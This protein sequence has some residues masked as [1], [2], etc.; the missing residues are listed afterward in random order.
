MVVVGSM[1]MMLV[2]MAVYSLNKFIT[3]HILFSVNTVKHDS[4]FI[5]FGK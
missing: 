4:L 2:V 5:R 3:E 1:M